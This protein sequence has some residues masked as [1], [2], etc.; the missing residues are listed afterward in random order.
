MAQASK[1]HEVITDGELAA[2]PAR[3]ERAKHRYNTRLSD[4]PLLDIC[5]PVPFDRIRAAHV[6]PAIAALLDE[7]RLRLAQI[8]ADPRPRTWENTPA[9]LDGLTTRLDQALEIVRHLE[10]VATCAELRE[11]YNKVQPLASAFYAS[12]P[13]EEPLWRALQTYA[14]TEE[15]RSLQ[16]VRRRFFTKTLD[17]FRRHGAGLPAEEK[18]RLQQ[19]EVELAEL[20]TRFAQNVLDSTNA[21]ELVITDERRLAGLP[22]S[23]LAAARRSAAEKGLAGWRFTLQ[24]PSYVALM[25]YLDDAEVRRQVYLAYHTRAI[26][27]P[28]DNRPL[29]R[30]ILELRRRKANLLGYPDFAALTLEDRMARSPARVREFLEDLRRRTE[31]RFREENAELEAFRREREGPGAPPIEPWDLAYYA[32]KLRAARY[33]FDEEMLR[34]YFPLEQVVAGMF[35]LAER[36]FAVRIQPE[37]N[38]PV[39]DPQVRCYLVRDQDGTL[40]GAFYTDWYPRENKRGGAWM[41]GLITGGPSPAGFRPHVG[42]LCGN[43]TP[44]VDDRPALLTHREVETLFHEFGHLLHHCLSRVEIRSLA[45]TNVAWDFVELPSQIMENWCWER[46]A[47]DLFARHWET[48]EPLPEDLFARMRRARTFRAANAQMRQLGFAWL[49]LMLHT[50]YDPERDG[51]PVA[52]GRRTLQDF[53][54][55]PLPPEHALAASFTHLFAEPVGY[56]AGYYSYKWAEVLD[57]DA[58]T[59]SRREGIFNPETGAAFRHWILERGDSEDPAALYR[60]FMGRD[61]DPTALLERLGLLDGMPLAS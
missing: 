40:L 5:L 48:G 37:D 45:G 18:A 54:P 9:A 19:I 25:T 61:P 46:D 26:A 47:L 14:D 33:G 44:P 60:K 24:Q 3:K 11:A 7:A 50:E 15:G 6:E 1:P 10:S 16:G 13:L 8:G 55:V 59:R 56:G 22:A 30:R 29:V 31:G 39:W 58:F 20:T 34:P 23:A 4:N 42:V 27:A 52:Y 51:D 49:D 53:S 17:S 38:A 28:W 32:E 2:F 43:V 12:I 57:A 36:L 41:S 21:F 35:R